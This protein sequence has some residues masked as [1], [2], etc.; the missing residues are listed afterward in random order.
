[1][2]A[3]NRETRPYTAPQA[4]TVGLRFPNWTRFSSLSVDGEFADFPPVEAAR[5]G[6]W[7]VGLAAAL[8]WGAAASVIQLLPDIDDFERTTLLAQIAGGIGVL[9][10]IAAVGEAVF[11]ASLPEK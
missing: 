1:M 2:P 3:R 4:R 7:F 11:R 9:L 10:L 6:F 8:G 5:S